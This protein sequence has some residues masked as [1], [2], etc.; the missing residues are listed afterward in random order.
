[1]VCDFAW[2]SPVRDA[3]V[4][5]L[6]D[7]DACA[8]PGRALLDLS[9]T[10][11]RWRRAMLRAPL[12]EDGVARALAEAR[13]TSAPSDDASPD[14]E[15]LRALAAACRDVLAPLARA[16]R[17][18]PLTDAV[19]GALDAIAEGRPVPAGDP[20]ESALLR[21]AWRARLFGNGCLV[22]GRPHT[23]LARMALAWLV[24]RHVGGT[25][26]DVGNV[27]AAR[28][29]ET[30]YPPLLQAMLPFDAAARGIVVAAVARIR[31]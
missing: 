30:P 10:V 14:D 11:E 13:D 19:I 9:A 5:R 15:A 12:A 20:E 8:D 31:G 2:F 23:A 27:V 24:T 6:A 7:P 1:V 21:R 18:P 4:E 17:P 3:M 26:W 29:L 28:R 16:P 22:E 25:R